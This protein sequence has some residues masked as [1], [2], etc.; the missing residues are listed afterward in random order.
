MKLL[1]CLIVIRAKGGEK[2]GKEDRK[3]ERGDGMVGRVTK[4]GTHK[5]KS[6]E[7]EGICVFILWPIL[8]FLGLW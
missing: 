1:V 2:V 3:C 4:E 6:L 8:L 7:E 5:Q